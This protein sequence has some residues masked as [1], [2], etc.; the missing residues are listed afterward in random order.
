MVSIR[1][2]PLL[3]GSVANRVKVLARSGTAVSAVYSDDFEV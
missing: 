2:E 1:T 3:A